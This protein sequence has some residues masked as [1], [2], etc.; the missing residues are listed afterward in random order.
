MSKTTS[1]PMEEPVESE[2]FIDAMSQMSTSVNIVTTHGAAGRGGVTVSA[3]CSVSAERPTVLACVHHLSPAAA[4]I[5]ENGVF[6][7][8][9]LNDAQSYIADTFAG[10]IKRADGDKFGCADWRSMATGSPAL[11]GSLISFDCTVVQQLRWDTHHV[12]LG[13][14]VDVERDDTQALPLIYACRN[15]GSPKFQVAAE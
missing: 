12:F 5:E 15:Y 10:R 7:I 1:K 9:V 11:I 13:S 4:L 8:N 6:C 2:L 3:M 14:V